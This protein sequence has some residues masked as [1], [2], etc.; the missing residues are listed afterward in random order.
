MAGKYTSTPQ[1]DNEARPDFGN[2]MFWG[3]A[4]LIILGAVLLV[5]CG[6]Q[7]EHERYLQQQMFRRQREMER[8]ERIW[9]LQK[10]VLEEG[11]VYDFD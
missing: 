1:G 4:V 11:G 6:L 2:A 3:I 5:N 9:E 8:Q 10:A 7:R